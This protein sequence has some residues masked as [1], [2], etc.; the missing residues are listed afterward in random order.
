MPGE[1]LE[2]WPVGYTQASNEA[3]EGDGYYFHMLSFSSVT[4]FI[5]LIFS[6]RIDDRTS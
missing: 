3:A 4:Q 6:A 2:G 1:E 5:C